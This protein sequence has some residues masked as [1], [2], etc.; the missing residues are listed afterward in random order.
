MEN[1]G[2]LNVFVQAAETRS[3]TAAG[4]QLGISSSAVGKA[5]ARLEQRLGVRL[6]H[7][8]TR[9]VTLTP[10]GSLFLERCRRIFC[11]IEAA[12]LELSKTRAEP[13]GVLRVSLPLVGMLL[14]P[15]LI[16]FMREWPAIQLDLDFTDRLTDVIEEGFDAVI[17]TGEVSDSRLMTRK[18][19]AFRYKLVG[20]PAYFAEHGTPKTPADLATH[21]C[22][23]HRYPS[24][25]KLEDWP[26]GDELGETSGA[27]T[28]EIPAAAISNTIEP[29]LDMAK[30]GLGIACL[31][32]F[33][34]RDAISQGALVSVLEK[35]VRHGGTFRILWPSSRHLSP[36][37][38]VFVDFMAENLF[39][40]GARL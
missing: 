3:F 39:S 28:A 25:G 33:A 32:D 4:R 11:E 36:K 16:A 29:L 35:F 38:R 20:A 31:P 14:M 5:I 1:L 7:R 37:L 9:A 13:R 2:A 17:R 23:R 40:E 30:A 27:H 22:L 10:E 24:T 21:R 18:L 15:T 8:S 19:G 12:E 26:L 6:F 34:V